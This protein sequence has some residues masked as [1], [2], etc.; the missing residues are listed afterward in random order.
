MSVAIIPSS[1]ETTHCAHL[2]LGANVRLLVQRRFQGGGKVTKHTVVDNLK[3]F[4][5]EL[6]IRKMSEMKQ[7]VLNDHT[8]LLVAGLFTW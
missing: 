7:D 2:L 5:D 3:I 8:R 6:N 1:K 4:R